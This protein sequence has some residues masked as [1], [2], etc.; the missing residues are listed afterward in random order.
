[1]KL[2][3]NIRDSIEKIHQYYGTEYLDEAMNH[4]YAEMI[5]FDY[6]NWLPVLEIC[7]SK[8]YL[9]ENL[10]QICMNYYM[11][12]GN[13]KVSADF[14][15]VLKYWKNKG[16]NDLY[17]SNNFVP[18]NEIYNEFAGES[19]LDRVKKFLNHNIETAVYEYNNSFF[20]SGLKTLYFSGVLNNIL[21]IRIYYSCN[22]LNYHQTWE[23]GIR[24]LK[25]FSPNND[26]ITQ[27][28]INVYFSE[29][30]DNSSD[31]ELFKNILPCA[32]GLIERYKDYFI[33][34]GFNGH[35]GKLTRM[36]L[37]KQLSEKSKPSICWRLEMIQ[38]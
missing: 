26:G 36:I 34:L 8:N 29:M 15:R 11:W 31:D 33:V 30:D 2:V 27:Q 20:Y 14:A 32:P 6:I 4:V 12:K 13:M 17:D 37:Y 21:I 1:M 18:L 3:G 38:N 23:Y 35:S 22:L 19:E 10:L 16:L 7:V 9:P 24:K 5:Q 25:S 28:W